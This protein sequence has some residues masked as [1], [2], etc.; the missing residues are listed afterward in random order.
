MKIKLVAMAAA[1]AL[2]LS[3]AGAS[4]AADQTPF[5]INVIEPLTGP[6][7]FIGQSIVATLKIVETVVNRQGGIKGRPVKFVIS[8]DGSNPQVTVQLMARL[9]AERPPFIIGPGF[10]ATCAAVLPLVS[11][12]GPVTWCTSPAVQP[13]PGSYMFA[14]G[15]STPDASRAL[16]RYFLA[17]GWKR[18]AVL[19]G[20]DVS[21]Q[22]FE[23]GVRTFQAYP[24]G[25]A[26]DV[27][28]WEHTNNGDVSVAAQLARIKATNPQAIFAAVV[29]PAFATVMRGINDL[30]LDVP[31]GA[32]NG[33]M[34]RAQLVSYKSL[35]PPQIYFPGFLAVVPHSVG[36][37]PIEEAQKPFFAAFQ[38]AGA[39]I[40]AATQSAWDPPMIL[41]EALRK[42]GTNVSTERLH[43]YL[44][45]LHGYVGVEGIYDFRD[46]LQR[47][48]GINALVVD[49]W[50]RDKAAF[51]PV[52]RPAGYLK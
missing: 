17:R 26:L 4:R 43:Q 20:T 51:V 14:T 46:G 23:N 10:G 32:G 48:V 41:I 28:A 24:E 49:V 44:L 27:V 35:L 25:K 5:E 6:A 29:G 11:Q 31:V 34:I 33:N 45:N 38:E 9:I 50:D 36:R 39:V 18:V 47:G 22:A 7:A 16:M 8:D 37:G 21:G 12:N 3:A 1:L 15:A 42:L 2:T 19:A 30:G 40:D 13:P 52:S